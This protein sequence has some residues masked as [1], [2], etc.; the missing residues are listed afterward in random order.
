MASLLQLLRRPHLH[1]LHRNLAFRP[2]YERFLAGDLQ[3]LEEYCNKASH[4]SASFYELIGRLFFFRRYG[5]VE[6][7]L[8]GIDPHAKK[9]NKIDL[10]PTYDH[11]YTLL[12]PLCQRARQFIREARR[13]RPDAS[14]NKLWR[15]YLALA[16]STDVQE[17][18]DWT[19]RHTEASVRAGYSRCGFKGKKL[20]WRT[21]REFHFENVDRFSRFGLVSRKIFDDLAQRQP[22]LWTPAVVARRYACWIADIPESWARRKTMRK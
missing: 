3:A 2:Y 6:R 20:E 21:R 11:W 5:A 19:E 12:L 10:W 15:D 16:P 14:R 7:T 4:L 17:L 8:A 1:D 13:S 22:A 18:C 9:I